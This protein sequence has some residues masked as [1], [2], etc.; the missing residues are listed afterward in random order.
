MLYRFLSGDF[1]I[2][3]AVLLLAALWVRSRPSGVLD[4]IRGDTP[5]WNLLGRITVGAAVVMPLWVAAADNWRQLFGYAIS[6]TQRWQTDPFETPPTPEALRIVSLVLIVVLIVGLAAMY[7]RHHGSVG[8]ALLFA[9][10]GVVYFFFMNS[11]RIRLDVL[12]RRSEAAINHPEPLG[13]AFILFWALGLYILLATLVYAGGTVLFVL[14][15]LAAKLVYGVGTRGR[16]AQDDILP[17]VYHRKASEVEPPTKPA[18]PRSD[19]DL[20]AP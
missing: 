6:R 20:R 11:I 12:L 18:P 19:G 9:A 13:L 16:E 4:M 3:I 7:A 2:T 1:P 15:M 10:V 5:V 17:H 14:P 8:A